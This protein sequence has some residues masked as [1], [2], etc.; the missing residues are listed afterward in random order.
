MQDATLT[1][2]ASGIR[3]HCAW[4]GHLRANVDDETPPCLRSST[5]CDKDD[6]IG[7]TGWRREKGVS[8]DG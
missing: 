1:A 8:D 6:S 7:G 3:S 4:Q 5:S 2:P